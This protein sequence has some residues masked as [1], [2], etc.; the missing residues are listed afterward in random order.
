ME[1][2]HE[3]ACVPR[4]ITMNHT[5]RMQTAAGPARYELCYPS[6]FETG[7]GFAFPCDEQGHVIVDELSERGRRS[8]RDACDR[9]G[10]ELGWP[11]V[12]RRS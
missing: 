6:L 3:T 1:T 4:K 12:A 8:Y 11:S 10:T 9:V 2:G 5:S 7:H